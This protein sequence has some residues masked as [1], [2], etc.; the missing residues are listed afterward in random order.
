MFYWR[1]FDCRISQHN[2]TQH[3]T[4][5]IYLLKNIQRF[6]FGSFLLKKKPGSIRSII[7]NQYIKKYFYFNRLLTNSAIFSQSASE[8]EAKGFSPNISSGVMPRR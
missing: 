2:T 3:N 6:S 7:E 8:I 1:S 5:L 4:A